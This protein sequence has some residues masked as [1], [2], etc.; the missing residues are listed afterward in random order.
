MTVADVAY[1]VGP[2]RKKWRIVMLTERVSSL[3]DA[4]VTFSVAAD[5]DGLPYD[6]RSAAVEMA[7]VA[8]F[9]NPGVDDWFAGTWDVTVIGAFTAEFNPGP[10]GRALAPGEYYVWLRI[11]DAYSGWTPVEPCGKL[12]VS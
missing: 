10:S 8:S 9:D 12:I 1:R 4:P 6:P 3:S 7:A 5:V 11:T 2:P